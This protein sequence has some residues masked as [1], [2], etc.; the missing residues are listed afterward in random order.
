[1]L[2]SL[3]AGRK[4]DRPLH[5]VRRR[6]DHGGEAAQGSLPHP[7]DLRHQDGSPGGEHPEGPERAV[8][9]ALGDEAPLASNVDPSPSDEPD[10]S[11]S[12]EPAPDVTE[13]PAEDANGEVA[14][15]LSGRVIALDP[16]HNGGNFDAPDEINEPVDAGTETK[17][18]NTPGAVTEDGY[19]ESTFNLELAEHLRGELEARGAKVAMTREDD[20]GVGPCIDERGTFGQEVGADVLLSIHADGADP[21]EHGFHVIR[22]A[23]WEEQSDIAYTLA[24]TIEAFLAA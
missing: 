10:S 6:A 7:D 21:A 14:E 5:L 16:G 22:P 12:E 23:G 15:A 3:A 19:R 18:C 24:D 9:E 8:R 2:V 4:S 13:E 11:T 20:E 17:P 1:M